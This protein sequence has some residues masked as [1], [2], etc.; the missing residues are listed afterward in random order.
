MMHNIS[1]MCIYI[2]VYSGALD[3]VIL[4]SRRHTSDHIFEPCAP[5]LSIV[6]TCQSLVLKLE[7]RR[8]KI[9]GL[10]LER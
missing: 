2:Y 9:P 8:Y 10:Q 3:D 6:L 7:S 4:A 1:D 5:L